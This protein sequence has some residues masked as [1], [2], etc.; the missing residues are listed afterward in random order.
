MRG[1][2]ALAAGL[3]AAIG[4][5]CAAARTVGAEAKARKARAGGKVRVVVVTGGH[6]Y[7]RKAFPKLFQGHEDIDFVIA[8]QMDHSELFEDVGDW[9]H[10]VIVFY[11][12]TQKITPRRRENFLKLLRRGVGVVAL[13]HTVAAFQDWPEFER[14][15]GVKY[16]LKPYT[17][18]GQKRPGSGYKHGVDMKIH[19][20]DAGHPITRGVGDFTVH[21]ESY[22]RQSFQPGNHLL[23]STDHKTSDKPVAWVRSYG[24]ARVFTLQLG[25]GPTIFADPNYR[26]IVAQ[27]IRWAA[28]R[29]AGGEPEAGFRPLFNGKDLTGWQGDKKLWI[30][31]KGM[32]IGRSPGIRHNDFLATTKTYG[33]FVLRFQI[34]LIGG[35]GNS[36]VQFRSKRVPN[37]HEVSGYQ[38][39]VGGGW[40]GTLYD[41]AR[42][43]R[44]LARPKPEALKAVQRDGWNDY[45]VR[46]VGSR[47]TLTINGVRMADYKEPDPKIARSGIIAPQ[48]HGGGPLEVQFR[49]LR[50]KETKPPAPKRAKPRGEP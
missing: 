12:M 50:I 31:E 37:S 41:E 6:G 19:V 46:A 11:S 25:H 47:I 18:G 28:G 20:E 3:V 8:P 26:R 15:I 29:L 43:N 17:V 23:L 42:R 39:D 24:G 33:D 32:L 36:G 27:S 30:V 49:N 10:D 34:R 35:K 44:A 1:D 7:D 16:H 5:G 2:R 21:D 4:L 13:H 45:E 14:I 9:K 48:I 22:C 38:A 40:W